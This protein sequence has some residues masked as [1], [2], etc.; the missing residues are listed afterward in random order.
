MYK[1]ARTFTTE[2]FYTGECD[3]K[4]PQIQLLLVETHSKTAPHTA[5]Q[6]SLKQIFCCSAGEGCNYS[7]YIPEYKTKCRCQI[8]ADNATS[9]PRCDKT[10]CGQIH[11]ANKMQMPMP[12]FLF[13][14]IERMMDLCIRNI[15]T[16]ETLCLPE[17]FG[18][19]ALVLGRVDAWY[20]CV[21]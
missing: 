15:A 9:L 5:Y 19:F 11:Y 20:F 16:D 7:R 1:N 17:Y 12:L 18:D 13:V 3:G 14:N 4:P 2:P 21:E 8:I 10:M 6:G